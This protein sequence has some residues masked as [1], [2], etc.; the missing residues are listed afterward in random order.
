MK[1]NKQIKQNKQDIDLSRQG[2]RGLKEL[3]DGLDPIVLAK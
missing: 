1:N 3:E 2:G